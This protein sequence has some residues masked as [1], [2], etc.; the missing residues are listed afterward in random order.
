MG[1]DLIMVKDAIMFSSPLVML[2]QDE[3]FE[4]T[5]FDVNVSQCLRKKESIG[6]VVRT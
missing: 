6:R 3:K 4:K 1:G 5:S 2:V